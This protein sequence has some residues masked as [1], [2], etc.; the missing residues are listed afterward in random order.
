MTAGITRELSVVSK[1]V[2]VILMYCGRVG[3]LS[4]A[5]SFSESKKMADVRYPT[6]EILIG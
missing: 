2:L 5:L 1:L 6:E 4:F 3:S